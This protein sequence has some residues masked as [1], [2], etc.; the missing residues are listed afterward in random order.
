L[1]RAVV[2]LAALAVLGLLVLTELSWR[3][4][5]AER[6]IRD[7][8]YATERFVDMGV[9]LKV[10]RADESGEVLLSG[11]PRMVVVAEHFFGGI[12]DTK[13]P[14]P[15]FVAP[16]EKPVVWLASEDQAKVLLAPELEQLAHGSEGSGKSTLLAMWHAIRGVF[17]HLGEKRM[18]AQTAP[19]QTRLTFVRDE[20]LRL[21]PSTWFRHFKALDCFVFCDGS[22]I[23][24]IS[25]HKQSAAEGSRIQGWNLSWIGRDEL[26]DQI[27]VHED[28]ESRGRAARDGLC[29]Q[30]ATA[31]GK[32][33]PAYRTLRAKLIEAG[34]LK[35]TLSIFRSPF[36][37]KAFIDKKKRSMSAREFLRR[38]GDPNTGELVDLLPERLLYHGFSREN[39]RP[40][41]ANARKVTTIT[42][43]KKWGVPKVKLARGQNIHGQT[44]YEVV[45]GSYG[46]LGGHDPGAAK[47]GTI[48]LDAY[49]VPGIP[50]LAWWVRGELFHE[51]ETTQESARAIVKAVRGGVGFKDPVRLNQPNQREIVKVVAHPYGQSEN[52]PSLNLYRIFQEEGVD[53]VAAQFKKDGTGTGKIS[54]DDRIDNVNYLF[55]D[56]DQVRRLFIECDDRGNVTAPKLLEA[57]ETMERDENGRAETDEKKVTTDKSDLPAGLGY[58]LWVFEKPSSQFRRKA[59]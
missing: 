29:P 50:G 44:Q 42:L 46:L 36:V 4:K 58:A 27:E 2:I 48:F 39:I 59:A 32:D 41:P 33:A 23:Q 49:E 21:F 15:A 10:V 57:I 47:G 16:S 20:M 3:R 56:V 40:I 26:Q 12:V 30:L 25:T 13:L 52:K 38:F 7:Y 53:V 51:R 11:K 31:T 1:K 9:H 19:T 24:L 5:K 14:K 34:W 54:K 17:E 8:L 55:C 45:E 35:T 37:T 43:R 6:E 28:L 22:R 18:G